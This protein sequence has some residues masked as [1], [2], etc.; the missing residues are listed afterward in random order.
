M[1]YDIEDLDE[2]KHSTKP[3]K[4]VEMNVWQLI[5]YVGASL[6]ALHS[7]MSLMT[8]HRRQHRRQLLLEYQQQAAGLQQSATAEKK[9]TESAEVAA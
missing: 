3:G 2:T 1:C 6:I 9:S 4:G 7:L 8:Q 5:L